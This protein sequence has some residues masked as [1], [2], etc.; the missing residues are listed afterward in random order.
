VGKGERLYMSDQGKVGASWQPKK[1]RTFVETRPSRRTGGALDLSFT[2]SLRHLFSPVL[3]RV[4]T[5]ERPDRLRLGRNGAV[6]VTTFLAHH[7]PLVAV[8]TRRF[9]TPRGILPPAPMDRT[10][11]GVVPS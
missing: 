11:V 6:G 2:M 5:A 7:F 1:P 9:P 10:G 8:L 4:R 3:G